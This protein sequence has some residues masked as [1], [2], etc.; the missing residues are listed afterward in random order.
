MKHALIALLIAAGPASAAEPWATY[1]GN[2]QRTGNTDGRP[3]PD[4]PA[5][6][7]VLKPDDAQQKDDYI[8]APVPVGDG[9]YVAGR[10][11]LNRPVAGLF[12]LDSKASPPERIWTLTAPY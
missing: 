4:K 6:L 10:G 1:R 5:V 7:W 9:V 3:G 8:A 2:P 12:R 11:G